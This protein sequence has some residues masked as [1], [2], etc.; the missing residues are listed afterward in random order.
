MTDHTKSDKER[1]RQLAEM[2][3]I[4]CRQNHGSFVQS[5]VAHVTHSGRRVGHKATIP[6]CPWHHRGVAPEGLTQPDMKTIY[7]PSFAKGKAE[8]EAAFGS[9]DSLLVATN[10]W[11]GIE[12]PA[13]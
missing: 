4:V 13:P 7:G 10:I 12:K 5:E 9:E 6:L 3:C 1:F 8:F 11:L 2:G